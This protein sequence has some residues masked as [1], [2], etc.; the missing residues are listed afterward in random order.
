MQT[1]CDI[2]VPCYNCCVRAGLDSYSSVLK[3]KNIIQEVDVLS[4]PFKITLVS[5]TGSH[6]ASYQSYHLDFFL[7]PNIW[8]HNQL[9]VG[10]TLDFFNPTFGLTI[11][12]Q[13]ASLLTFF[14][15]LTFGVTISLH[16]V[17]LLIFFFSL[18]FGFTSN[19]TFGFTSNFTFGFTL[20]KHSALHLAIHSASRKFLFSYMILLF[21][22]LIALHPASHGV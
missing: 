21:S 18:T 1:K 8:P 12:L 15:N 5:Y 2:A 14:F 17:S 6:L 16:L 7:Q 3:G 11:S 13:F 9:T 19:F 10:L 4:L 22:F 20:A